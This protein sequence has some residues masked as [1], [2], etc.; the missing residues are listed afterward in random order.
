[1]KTIE[2][3]QAFLK[4]NQDEGV[5]CPCCGQ[6]VK[7]Y[8]RSIT[9][10][11]AWA[12]LLVHRHMEKN[13]K[14]E[15]VHVQSFLKKQPVPAAVMSGDFSKMLHWQLI[16]KKHGVREDGSKR[17]GFYALTEKGKLFCKNKVS[18]KEKAHLYNQSLFG[19]S[20][21]DVNIREVLKKKFDYDQLMNDQPSLL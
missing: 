12:L 4:K 13:P 14:L 7:L 16:I 6:Y 2:E 11:M 10:S 18:V 5:S 1:M 8:H 9:S 3:A 20:G 19:F 15:W 21:K 17:V